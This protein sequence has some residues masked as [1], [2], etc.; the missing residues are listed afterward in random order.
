MPPEQPPQLADF[1]EL[2]KIKASPMSWSFREP[3]DSSRQTAK[4][5]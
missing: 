1:S 3:P 4:I 5:V 2:G